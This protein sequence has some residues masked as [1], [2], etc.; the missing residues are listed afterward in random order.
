MSLIR[1][2]FTGGLIEDEA[3]FKQPMDVKNKKKYNTATTYTSV[4]GV[5]RSFLTRHLHGN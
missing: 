2:K 3:K 1:L 5:S 4:L